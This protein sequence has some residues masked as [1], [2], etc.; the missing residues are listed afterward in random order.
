M[1]GGEGKAI[2][3]AG[4]GD[5]QGCETDGSESATWQLAALYPQEDFC[6][7]VSQHQGHSADERINSIKSN[8]WPSSM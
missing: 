5:P 8:P 4:L 6:L 1:G 2:P 3:V 7:R